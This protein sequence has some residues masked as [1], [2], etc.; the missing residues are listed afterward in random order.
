[1]QGFLAA[2]IRSLLNL[3]PAA[4]GIPLLIRRIAVGDRHPTSLLSSTSNELLI[5]FY[6]FIPLWLWNG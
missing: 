4:E 1:M 5:R 2:W 6:Q 3:F